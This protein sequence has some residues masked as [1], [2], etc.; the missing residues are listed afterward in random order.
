[1]FKLLFKLNSYVHC[2]R[3]CKIFEPYEIVMY[4]EQSVSLCIKHTLTYCKQCQKCLLFV[5]RDGNI[6]ATHVLKILFV[7][8][9]MMFLTNMACEAF[10]LC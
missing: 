9:Q 5:I 10:T 3:I 2:Y 1:M 7:E 8:D 4:V 6:V